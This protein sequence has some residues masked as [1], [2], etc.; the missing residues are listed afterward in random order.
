MYRWIALL[1]LAFFPSLVSGFHYSGRPFEVKPNQALEVVGRQ[2]AAMYDLCLLNI[3]FG[4][5]ADAKQAKWALSFTSRAK[6]T[7]PDV[8]PMVAT[9]IRTFLFKIYQDPV[10]LEYYQKSTTSK[11]LG[12]DSVAFKLAFWDENVDRPLAPFLAQVRYADGVVYYHYANPSTQA[13]QEP[14][15]ET[16]ES[17]GITRDQYLCL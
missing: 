15:V 7:I 10:F 2:V 3:S 11:Q 13:L 4:E 5:L 6:M 12:N 8:R 16:I 14:V 1:V 17:L 9:M